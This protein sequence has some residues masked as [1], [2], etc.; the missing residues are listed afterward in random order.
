MDL[1]KLKKLIDLVQESGI[2]ELEITEGEEKVRIA[3]G[4]TVSMTPLASGAP[5]AKYPYTSMSPNP[6]VVSLRR[7]KVRSFRHRSRRTALNACRS[8]FPPLVHQRLSVVH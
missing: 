3:R 6:C 1:R 2:A 5:F 7:R 8:Y 4:G